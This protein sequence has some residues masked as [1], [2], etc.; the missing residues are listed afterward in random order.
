MAM[1]IKK[2]SADRI[3]G[4]HFAREKSKCPCVISYHLGVQNTHRSTYY[5]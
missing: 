3:E 2:Q 1:L 4:Q 5:L